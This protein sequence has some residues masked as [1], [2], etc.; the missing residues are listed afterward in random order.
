MNAPAELDLRYLSL[1]AAANVPTKVAT[2]THQFYRYPARFGEVF[3]REAILNFSQAGDTVLDPFCGGG[4]AIVEA[5]SLGRRAIGNDLSK[6]AIAISKVKT[7]PLSGAQ[8][9]N[10]EAWLDEATLKTGTR[11]SRQQP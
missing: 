4:T 11:T 6:L 5:L 8:L 1:L 9:R 7:S 2:F 3:V 10:I